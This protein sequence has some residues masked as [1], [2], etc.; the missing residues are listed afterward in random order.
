MARMQKNMWVDGYI[1]G[2]QF[3][4][5]SGRKLKNTL[6]SINIDPGR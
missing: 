3:S 4:D 5:E 6:W 1:D 2:Y